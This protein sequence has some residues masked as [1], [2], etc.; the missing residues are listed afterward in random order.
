MLPNQKYLKVFRLYGV[1]SEKK[2]SGSMNH[3]SLCKETD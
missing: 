3:G 2:D 1:Y